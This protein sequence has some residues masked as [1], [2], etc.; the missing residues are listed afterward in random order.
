MLRL[1][2][3]CKRLCRVH[4]QISLADDEIAK[5]TQELLSRDTQNGVY[6]THLQKWRNTQVGFILRCGQQ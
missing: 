4:Q 5:T 6:T 3:F 1:L 2:L